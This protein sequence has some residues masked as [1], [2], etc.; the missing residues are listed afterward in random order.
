LDPEEHSTMSSKEVQEDEELEELSTS[1]DVLL[2]R[3]EE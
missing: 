2:N 1:I 3:L